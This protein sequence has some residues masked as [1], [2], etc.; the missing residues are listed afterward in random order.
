[1]FRLIIPPLFILAPHDSS[2]TVYVH[3]LL[4]IDSERI[5]VP[6]TLGL[7][8]RAAVC[9]SS[10]IFCVLPLQMSKVLCDWLA[11]ADISEIDLSC[12]VHR[13]YFRPKQATAEN[14]SAI[15]V[16]NVFP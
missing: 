7:F 8:F 5:S 9:A 13:R 6:L 12:V 1:M 11:R 14:T 2:F 3:G 15:A 16:F 10:T 4:L